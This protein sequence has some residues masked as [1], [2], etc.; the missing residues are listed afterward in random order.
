MKGATSG[1]VPTRP[2]QRTRGLQRR[3]DV[4]VPETPRRPVDLPILAA[5]EPRTRPPPHAKRSFRPLQA[6]SRGWG[7]ARDI[8]GCPTRRASRF[9]CLREGR[10]LGGMTP[11]G[12]RVVGLAGPGSLTRRHARRRRGA[13][14]GHHRARDQEGEGC[15]RRGPRRPQ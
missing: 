11:T 14:P 2:A 5:K 12:A 1:P 3:A 9:R 15:A 10:T 6:E 4:G 13:R 8:T 7:G